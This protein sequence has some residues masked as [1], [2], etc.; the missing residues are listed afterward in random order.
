M[1]QGCNLY[2]DLCSGLCL[3]TAFGP[4]LQFDIGGV[5]LLK[6]GLELAHLPLNETHLFLQ[7]C[8]CL[9]EQCQPVYNGAWRNTMLQVFDWLKS[10]R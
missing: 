8:E 7:D 2:T 9:S 6:S 5:L 3:L 4:L 10:T 1:P